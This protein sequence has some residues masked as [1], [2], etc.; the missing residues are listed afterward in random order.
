MHAVNKHNVCSPMFGS[1]CI[2]NYCRKHIQ[3]SI[4]FKCLPSSWWM[5]YSPMLSHQQPGHW[6]LVLCG[7][8]RWFSRI[9]VSWDLWHVYRFAQSLKAVGYGWLSCWKTRE[10]HTPYPGRDEELGEELAMFSFFQHNLLCWSSEWLPFEEE[11][12]IPLDWFK[13]NNLLSLC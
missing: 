7:V 9:V 4:L 8:V 10:D 13:E 2:L 3:R 12:S 5:D 6:L 1:V 11:H